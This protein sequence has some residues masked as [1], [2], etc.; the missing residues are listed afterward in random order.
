M[1]TILFC[2]DIINLSFWVI[3]QTLLLIILTSSYSPFVLGARVSVAPSPFPGLRGGEA[4]F[5]RASEYNLRFVDMSWGVYWLCAPSQASKLSCETFSALLR[6]CPA[7]VFSAL[8]NG[9][10]APPA[11]NWL[12]CCVSLCLPFSVR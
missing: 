3:F 1:L 10:S 2:C 9:S 4:F 11:R 6:N 7:R 12:I 5:I 8:G